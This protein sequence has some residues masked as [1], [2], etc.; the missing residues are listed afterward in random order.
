MGLKLRRSDGSHGLWT[1]PGARVNQRH[2]SGGWAPWATDS[3]RQGRAASGRRQGIRKKQLGT[4]A[5]DLHASKGL[6]VMGCM[7]PLCRRCAAAAAATA[8]V[9]S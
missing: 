3:L 6:I 8:A 4:D 2:A 7:P 1:G 9:G 5:V